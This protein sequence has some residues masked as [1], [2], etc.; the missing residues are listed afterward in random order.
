MALES[1]KRNG[2]NLDLGAVRAGWSPY[3]VPCPPARTLCPSRLQW[4]RFNHALREKARR[5]RCGVHFFHRRLPLPARRG[6]TRPALRPLPASAFQAVHDA[7]LF[8]VLR[9]IRRAV[10]IYN[11]WRKHQLGAYWQRLGITVVPTVGWVGQEQLR[12]VLRRGAGGRHGRRILRWSAMKNPGC[13]RSCFI[14]GLSGNARP[15]C[16][17]EMIIFFRGRSG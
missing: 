3:G 8:H 11:H 2:H 6:T 10:Q 14:D 13:P 17:P 9:T 12:L 7:G 1:L 16:S 4:T 15:A 5:D